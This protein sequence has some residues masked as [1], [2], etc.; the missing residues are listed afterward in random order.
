ML[1]AT[2]FIGS[3]TL[4]FEKKENNQYQNLTEN[5]EYVNEENET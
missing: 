4:R 1:A 2:K 5:I 3:R